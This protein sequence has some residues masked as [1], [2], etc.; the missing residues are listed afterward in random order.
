MAA[1]GCGRD[2]WG[3]GDS[4]SS[5]V[6]RLLALSDDVYD[7][8][9]CAAW[10]CP[11]TSCEGCW[12]FLHWLADTGNYRYVIAKKRI[13]NTLHH[14][15]AAWQALRLKHR[16]VVTVATKHPSRPRREFH[17]KALTRDAMIVQ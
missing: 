2:A 12:R 9:K 13:K 16:A 7:G 4:S 17:F 6:S 10:G 11:G 8:P 5:I 3:D 14:D 1:L 15:T